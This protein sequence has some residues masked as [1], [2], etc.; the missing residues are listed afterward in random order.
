L[1]RADST[2]K[3]DQ[4]INREITAKTTYQRSSKGPVAISDC[5]AD[6]KYITLENMGLQVVTLK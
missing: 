6:G 2:T 5:S 3:V 1:F 4:Q